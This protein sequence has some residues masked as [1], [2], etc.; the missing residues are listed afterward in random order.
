VSVSALIV[1]LCV[2]SSLLSCWP[3]EDVEGAGGQSGDE[4]RKVKPHWL[5]TGGISAQ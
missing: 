2:L 5:G 3:P 4:G 1:V